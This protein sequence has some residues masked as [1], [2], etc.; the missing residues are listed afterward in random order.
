MVQIKKNKVK[1]NL[2][3]LLPDYDRMDEYLKIEIT[4]M[5]FMT[6]LFKIDTCNEK[7]TP[8]SLGLSSIR[9]GCQ[10]WME[11]ITKHYKNGCQGIKQHDS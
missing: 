11:A 3:C 10:T 8:L 6:L 7:K 1:G 5:L 4:K 2:W 9:T